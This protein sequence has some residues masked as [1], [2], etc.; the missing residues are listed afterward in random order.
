MP[1]TIIHPQSNFP[2]PTTS[3]SGRESR[4]NGS[5]GYAGI[6]SSCT[7]PRQLPKPE[8][9]SMQGFQDVCEWVSKVEP[10][11]SAR[12]DKKY[13]SLSQ[14]THPPES[15]IPTAEKHLDMYKA[16]WSRASELDPTHKFAGVVDELTSTAVER[17]RS[18]QMSPSRKRSISPC[19]ENFRKRSRL[20]SCQNPASA[21]S[22]SDFE[23]SDGT[24]V[25][26]PAEKASRIWP[27][28]FFVRDRV[29]YLGCWTRHCLL[30]VDDVR[31]HLCSMHLEPIHCSVCYETFPTVRLRDAHMRTQEC[32]YRLPV[33]F[34]GLTYSQVRE[35]ERQ[36]TAGDG[37]PGLQ[38]RQWVKIWCIVFSCTQLPPSPFYFS[39][40]EIAV[41][42]FRL[43][44]K[45]HGENIIADVLAEHRLQ[46]YEIENEERSL[47]ALYRLVADCGVDHLLF[48]QD[49]E[50]T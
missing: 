22:I 13:W 32:R 17:F 35:L 50:N 18:V 16:P 21:G 25:E 15:K 40:R 31:E 42:E 30:S 48:T 1:M 6:T 41:Y 33:V 28:P 7:S 37:A 45:T 36:R 20:G 49:T 23:E 47:Q 14:S 4:K 9:T 24:L 39:Q 12:E 5:H 44:W 3:I 27:C 10:G 11:N 26:H 8:V 38:A 43:F 2:T 46:Q 34:D 19:P 29:S